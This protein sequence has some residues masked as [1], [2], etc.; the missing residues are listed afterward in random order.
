MTVEKLH[1][2]IAEF[3]E[4]LDAHDEPSLQSQQASLISDWREKL[5]VALHCLPLLALAP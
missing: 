5:R 2:Y 3:R 4:W 1:Y